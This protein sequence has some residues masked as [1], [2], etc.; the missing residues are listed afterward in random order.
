MMKL[1]NLVFFLMKVMKVNVIFKKK[2]FL[3]GL[4]AKE[5]AESCFVQCRETAALYQRAGATYWPDGQVYVTASA[6]VFDAVKY[7][8]FG[9]TSISPYPTVSP[10]HS[11]SLSYSFSP[12]PLLE[13]EVGL[14]C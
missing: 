5:L 3:L 4:S 12:F 11:G 9:I 8:C 1:Q 6:G 2:C 14:V 7:K 10:H 13:R